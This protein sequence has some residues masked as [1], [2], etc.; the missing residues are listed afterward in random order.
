MSTLVT[1]SR[2]RIAIV[3]DHPLFRAGLATSLRRTADLEIVTVGETA[4]DAVRAAASGNVDVLLLDITIPGGGIEAARSIVRDNPGVRILFLTGADSEDAAAE[5]LAIGGRGY[6][7]KGANGRELVKAIR[8]VHQGQLYV[9]PELATRMLA[10]HGRR[11]AA[12]PPAPA[13][14]GP[15]AARPFL[16]LREQQILDLAARGLKNREIAAEL[17]LSVATVK[18][19][20]SLVVR[21][22]GVRNR[23][24]AVVLH[25]RQPQE[26]SLPP[27]PDRVKT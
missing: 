21:K 10:R 9:T 27:A 24:E 23:V 26:A 20:I 3:D 17:G 4:E 5:T 22:W 19:Y 7:L 2:I 16:S 18:H 14:P 1:S 6:V 25:S 15:A 12:P 13:R 11:E 8:T